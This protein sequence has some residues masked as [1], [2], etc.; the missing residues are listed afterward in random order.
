MPALANKTYFNYGGQGPLPTPS[1]AAINR[2][3]ATIQELGPF[4]ADVW[5]FV[6][7]TTTELRHR[8]A[9]WFG[10]GA[11]R[12][13]FT[14]NVTSGCVLPLWGLP[15]QEGD[16]L[17]LSDAEH[18]GVVAACLE[19][20]RRQRLAVRRFA[21]A[22]FRGTA[23]TSDAGVLDALD[24]HLTPRTRLVVLS[25]LLWNTGQTMP[26]E[27]VAA[28]LAAHPRH[29]WL[30]VDAAQSFGSLPLG[31]AAAVADIY[32]C[33]GHKWCCGPEGL[34]AVA[35]SERL[36][37]ESMPTLIGWRSLSN[38]GLPGSAFH[39]DARRFEV[40]T[41]CTPLFAGLDTSL[42]LLEAEGDAQGRLA[43]I[44][45]RSIQLWSGLQGIASL[46][47]LLEIPPPAGLVS[48]QVTGSDGAA[49]VRRLGEQGIWLRTLDD[50]PCVRAC[51]HLT[52]TAAEVDLLLETLP[53]L[54]AGA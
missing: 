51:T 15:W 7:R 14:E 4:T 37:A 5:P 30:L 52:T 42:Q 43:A 17:L 36:L 27:A 35:L 26:I 49:L 50:P 32:A 46:E 9:A 20:A 11:D 54:S 22:Q 23:E 44:R 10:V 48:F 8:L 13:A 2:A 18:P 41:S 38:E 45:A 1:L 33:T 21:V 25:H 24:A 39:G 29:P 31:E 6:A 47:P 19:L 16:E 40:A 34:G 12:I 3:W 28:R 53:A